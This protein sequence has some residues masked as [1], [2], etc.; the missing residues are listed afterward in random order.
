[1]LW[2]KSLSKPTLFYSIRDLKNMNLQSLRD[3][4]DAMYK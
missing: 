1:M 3:A 4:I 2:A